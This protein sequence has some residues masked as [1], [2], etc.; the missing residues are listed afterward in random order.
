MFLLFLL[1]KKART[2]ERR[3]RFGPFQIHLLLRPEQ[4][5]RL[6]KSQIHWLELTRTISVA[7]IYLHVL[8]LS[9]NCFFKNGPFPAS[10]SLF[11]SSLYSI[12]SSNCFEIQKVCWTY[13]GQWL[14]LSWESGRFQYKRSTVRFESLAKLFNEHIYP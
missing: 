4:Y 9:S 10:F 8:S 7:K 14:W 13:L 5:L 1:S 12:F 11:S 2:V 6:L 3:N